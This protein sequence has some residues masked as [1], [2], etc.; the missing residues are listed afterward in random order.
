MAQE[1][2]QN[3]KDMQHL[4]LTLFTHELI[5]CFEGRETS[6]NADGPFYYW[7]DLGWLS[8]IPFSKF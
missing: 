7:I 3:I 6:S 2:H 4:L 8:P 5:K 1:N